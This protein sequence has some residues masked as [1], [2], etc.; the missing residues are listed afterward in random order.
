M[1]KPCTTITRFANETHDATT[2]CM[3][4]W[5]IHHGHSWYHSYRKLCCWIHYRYLWWDC[6]LM[7]WYRTWDR[8]SMLHCCLMLLYYQ[9]LHFDRWRLGFCTSNPWIIMRVKKLIC[10]EECRAYDTAAIRVEI[11][12][13]ILLASA[14]LHLS[15]FFLAAIS[16]KELFCML[17]HV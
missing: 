16:I 6:Y 15:L 7:L 1:P 11:T 13:I 9:M 2:T 8:N 10:E 5:K 17:F 12:L 3:I 14:L 4:W